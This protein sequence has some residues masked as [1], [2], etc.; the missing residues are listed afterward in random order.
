MRGADELPH[1]GIKEF[2]IEQLPFRNYYS[3]HAFYALMA[4]FFNMFEL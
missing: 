2:G 1:R 4:I 3:N